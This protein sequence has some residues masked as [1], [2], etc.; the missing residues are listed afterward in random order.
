MFTSREIGSI[1]FEEVKRGYNQT[2]VKAF[3]RKISEQVADMERER[4]TLTAQIG[5]FNSEKAAIEEKMLMLADK[6]EEYRS[7]EDSLRSALLS[8]QK[9][10]D[11]IVKEARENA[12]IILNDAQIK[13]DE[14]VKGASGKVEDE[15]E[16]LVRLKDEVSKF[17]SDVLSIYK[18]HLEVLSLIPEDESGND[19]SATVRSDETAV[20]SVS[21]AEEVHTPII[22]VAPFEPE[23]YI[24][25]TALPPAN[26]IQE[27][28]L[29]DPPL[30]PIPME[31]PLRDVVLEPEPVTVYG[32]DNSFFAP[33]PQE[34]N[35]S[36]FAMY[37]SAHSNAQQDD[38]QQAISDEPVEAVTSAASDEIP[39]RFGQLDFG[40]GFSFSSK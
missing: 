33:A 40:D 25:D 34:V 32:S 7:E 18:S 17:K 13:A 31:Q 28:A 11:N 30:T 3:L 36:P 16:V 8:A 27:D 2:D 38:V 39:S 37:S 20:V 24:P 6:V 21:Y 26:I 19:S 23:P 5:S 1:E 9:L 29:P 35:G 4:D 22:E 15:R 12:S 10:G 14:I